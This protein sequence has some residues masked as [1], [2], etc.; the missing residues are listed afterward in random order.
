VRDAGPPGSDR[1]AGVER[2]DADAR[3]TSA[4]DAASPDARVADAAPSLDLAADRPAPPDATPRPAPPDATPPADTG[5]PAPDGAASDGGAS[6]E[7]VLTGRTGDCQL[8][9]WRQRAHALCTSP[10]PWQAARQRCQG[11]G[12]DLAILDSQEIEVAIREV[13][14]IGDVWIGLSDLAT[15][16]TFVWVDGRPLVYR[17]WMPNE[18]ND[19]LGQEDCVYA[20]SG[21]GW[22]DA[23]CDVPR[24]YLCGR[25]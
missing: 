15:E 6:S 9:T 22:N 7:I 10:L 16:G 11:L 23:D 2:V 25:R 24:S 20:R 18:P 3:D 12:L 17:N 21:Q 4:P 19:A 1:D 13:V 5:A 8:F 14:T